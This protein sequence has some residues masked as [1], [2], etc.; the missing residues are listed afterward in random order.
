MNFSFAFFFEKKIRIYTHFIAI[1]NSW[2]HSTM[3]FFFTFP[4][5]FFDLISY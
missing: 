4:N 2:N 1:P 5:D 3:I